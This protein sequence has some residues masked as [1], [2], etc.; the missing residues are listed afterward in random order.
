[1]GRTKEEFFEHS[2]GGLDYIQH[3]YP[4]SKGTERNNRK[5]RIRESDRTPSASVYQKGGVWYV[6]DH[7]DSTPAMNA[8]DLCMDEE[9]LDF[10]E[11]LKWL[12]GFKGIDNTKNPALSADW[13][14]EPT[15]LDDGYYTIED[16]TPCNLD[17]IAPFLTPEVAEEYF[18]RSI[19]TYRFVSAQRDKAGN[20][21]KELQLNTVS[22]TDKYPLYCFKIP[23]PDSDEHFYKLYEPKA[24]NKAYRFRSFG[25]KPARLIYGWD[26]IFAK[27]NIE[28]LREYREEAAKETNKKDK[29]VLE[30]IIDEILVDKVIIAS[31]GSDGLNL[32]SL[33]YDVIWFNSETERI[34]EYE[35]KKLKEICKQIY[36]LPDLDNTGVEVARLLGL[37]FWYMKMIWLPAAL[38][39]E[40]KKDFKDW[41]FANKD[42]GLEKVKATF[43]DMLRAAIEC[44]WWQFA[45]GRGGG[46]KYKHTSLIQ[47]LTFQGFYRY[48]LQHKN[49][50]KGALNYILVKVEGHIVREVSVPDIKQ[51]V[52]QWAKEHYVSLKV[53]DMVISSQF[54]SE[55]GLSSLPEIQLNFR[56]A[57]EADQ[58][59]FFRHKVV[60]VSP[61]G[62]T[63]EKSNRGLNCHVWENKVID[64]NIKVD[65]D[66]QFRIAKN[67]AGQWDIEVLEK[68]N[69]FFNYLINA[70]RMH[71]RTELEEPFK[72]GDEK[73]KEAYHNANRFN[74]AGPNLGEDAIH[75]QKLHLINKIFSIG[76]LMH[77][78]KDPAKTWCLYVMDA[79][80]PTEEHQS[81]G[82]SGKSFC[83][84]SITRF[85]KN[86]F[87][88]EGR[89]PKLLDNQFIYDGVD[90][91]T[92]VVFVDDANRFLKFDFFFS[93]LT[94]TMRINPKH[95]KQFELPYE[96]SPKFVITT[97]YAPINTDASN[98]ERL[99]IM[100]F[101]DYYHGKTAD[102]NE[103]RQIPD[104]F[105][106]QRFFA[107]GFSEQQYNKFFNFCMQCLQ[108]FMGVALA[109]KIDAPGDNVEK[110][111]VVQ[112][113]GE[114]F[115]AW[116]DTYFS[117]EKLD[118]LIMRRELQDDY[119][120]FKGRGSKMESSTAQKK[121]LQMYCQLRGWNF[122]PKGM[123]TSDGTM[124]QRH[125][126]EATGKTTMQEFYYIDT[127][128][129]PDEEFTTGLSPV[130]ATAK[131]G[132]VSGEPDEDLPF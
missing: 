101:S 124:K 51:F 68:D 56:S 15:T 118:T 36:Y 82:R 16:I 67:P 76:Y 41:I 122:N 72:P 98:I 109:D 119:A 61:S 14:Q 49:Q 32:A 38:V 11:A 66:P 73:A 128:G 8:V 53:Q 90:E 94:G 114:D 75:E 10:A 79:K 127:K 80:I 81:N 131:A 69:M 102:Y 132:D 2:N 121:K 63:N 74:I 21:L 1:M 4:Q 70:S 62:I 115:R 9:G 45:D 34:N 44:K 65:K 59:Y 57:T 110:R 84:S 6:K 28:M 35:F 55:K 104:D 12:Y 43:D 48:S 24:A 125:T 20:K 46:Y 92:D 129:L 33:G 86:T 88:L 130:T 95:G 83:I 93:S 18:F 5:F 111:N 87:P 30:S 58:L 54:L 40:G 42:M 113:M 103:R 85:F 23:L 78:Y 97:N 60:R 112:Q 71:W 27:V 37:E 123:T 19:K 13:R 89:N 106:G 91:D 126:D 7:G 96:A 25:S 108:F 26:R 116:A 100:M 50:Q 105:N 29:A 120:A 3:V 52:L 47:F 107:E 77:A 17:I 99:L 64:H 22:A 117:P 39:K 31:G